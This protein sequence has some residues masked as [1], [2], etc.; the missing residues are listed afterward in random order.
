V[1]AEP[2]APLLSPRL[3]PNWIDGKDAAAVGGEKLEK[4][5][6]ANGKVQS[7]LARGRRQDAEKG[8]RA[9]RKA[10][11]DWASTTVV[12]RGEVLRR[13]AQLLE[14]SREEFASLVSRETG[15][16]FK[17]AHGEVGAAIEMGYFVAGEGR[18]FYGK[19]TTSAT[20]GKLA[21][22]SR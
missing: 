4:R 18:R 22:I 11:E 19:T 17:D 2:S 8:V 14:E 6:P 3:I 12:R 15:K 5:D 9:A 21:I 13:A 16:S 20:P 10:W 7:L 1:V